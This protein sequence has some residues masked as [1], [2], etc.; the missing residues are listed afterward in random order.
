MDYKENYNI[1]SQFLYGMHNIALGYQHV[2]ATKSFSSF[3]EGI[4]KFAV[5]FLEMIPIIGN[6][7]ALLEKKIKNWTVESSLVQRELHVKEY[8]KSKEFKVKELYFD[9]YSSKLIQHSKDNLTESSTKILDGSD[10]D[11]QVISLI[12]D[13]E[14]FKKQIKYKLSSAQTELL[15]NCVN[16]LNNSKKLTMVTTFLTDSSNKKEKEYWREQLGKLFVERINSLKEGESAIIPCGYMNGNVY[17]IEGALAGKVGG[18][19]MLIK[20]ERLPNG[21]FCLT[22]FNTGEGAENHKRL[23]GK[24]IT[25]QYFPINFDNIE[26]ATLTN[27]DFVKGFTGFAFNKDSLK[28]HAVKDIYVFLRDKLGLE[29]PVDIMKDKAY[30]DQ[31]SIC[32]NCSKKSL[33]VWLHNELAKEEK[34]YRQFRH[35]RLEKQIQGVGETLQVMGSQISYALPVRLGASDAVNTKRSIIQAVA[36]FF[37]GSRIFKPVSKSE[38]Q[39]LYDQGLKVLDKR[40]VKLTYDRGLQKIPK[41]SDL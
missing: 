6:L 3:F 4:A 35:F 31:G 23:K 34:L 8:V 5:G 40:R 18:H 12:R 11:I 15:T 39:N 37:R 30:Q 29:R 33:Q 21:R 38:V 17:D 13:L 26:L 2:K 14:S 10:Q 25:R 22:V 16:Q 19:S 41:K 20:V 36:G 9:T 27:E 28:K 24:G 32:G 7:P 1:K